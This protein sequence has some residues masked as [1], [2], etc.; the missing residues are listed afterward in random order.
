MR[1]VDRPCASGR[2]RRTRSRID[3]GARGAEGARTSA[4]GA[5][6]L[7]RRGAVPGRGGSADPACAR[8]PDLLL[9]ARDRGG[10][11]RDAGRDAD[12]V[13]LQELQRHRHALARGA[14]GDD[15]AGV[16]GRSRPQSPWPRRGIAG[17]ALDPHG[18]HPR[19][20]TPERGS[21]GACRSDPRDDRRR[22]ARQAAAE[23]RS[24]PASR[25][26]L[27]DGLPSAPVRPMC[28]ARLSFK[29]GSRSLPART[30]LRAHDHCRSQRKYS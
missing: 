2:R 12:A 11:D 24:R 18:S 30:R 13:L 1:G 28:R 5:A 23:R 3:H 14:G 6:R 16:A 21:Q 10:A 25:S 27:V 17:T 7:G 15:P 22:A 9:A 29:K 19:A 20:G 8:Q 26:V 4:R